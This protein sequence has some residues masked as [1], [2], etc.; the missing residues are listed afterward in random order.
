MFV[1]VRSCLHE[2]RTASNCIYPLIEHIWS[3]GGKLD[4]TSIA[5]PQHEVIDK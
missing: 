4:D 1:G 2:K 3:Q 5:V